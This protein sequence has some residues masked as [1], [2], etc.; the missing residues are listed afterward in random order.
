MLN[1]EPSYLRYVHDQLATGTLSPENAAAL[2]EGLIGLYEQEF[3]QNISVNKRQGLLNHLATWALFKGP[4]SAAMASKILN[5]SEGEV[6]DLIDRYSS[7]FNSPESGKYQ[8]YHE[9]LRVFIL[10]KL[11][12]NEIH[13][14]NEQIITY[15]E[16]AV[17]QADDSENE[18]YALQFLHN[19]LAL[20]SMLGVDYERL[21][22][23]VN[24]ESLW[25][26]Q[27]KV[28]KGY[29]WSQN[30][31][32]QGIKE[33]TRRKHEMNT[34]RSTVN[35]V[36]LMTQEQ[37]SAE[38]IIELLNEGDYHSALKR[39]ESWEGDRQFKLYLLFIHELTIGTSKEANFR[40]E[41]C[42]AVLEAIDQTPE[43]HSILDWT[44]FYPELAI[45][46]YYEQLLKMELD[47]MVIWK[48]GSFFLAP[49]IYQADIPLV[50]YLLP[51]WRSNSVK[52]NKRLRC[53]DELATLKLFVGKGY[54]DEAL[55]ILSTISIPL[56]KN[57]G[58]TFLFSTL[59]QSNGLDTIIFLLD[60]VQDD[61]ILSKLYAALVE[62]YYWANEDDKVITFLNLFLNVR[63][64]LTDYYER[65]VVAFKICRLFLTSDERI[66]VESL[67]N[68]VLI[69]SEFIEY[70]KGKFEV[71]FEVLELILVKRLV[72]SVKGNVERCFKV[73]S[74]ISSDLDRAS[75]YLKL[76]RL[77]FENDL[78][79]YSSLSLFR[80]LDSAS[81][82]MT[83]LEKKVCLFIEVFKEQLH[84]NRFEAA[85][86]TL[87]SIQILISEMSNVPY[88]SKNEKARVN[89]LLMEVLV[90]NEFHTEAEL[91]QKALVPLNT[92]SEFYEYQLRNNQLVLFR[93]NMLASLGYDSL[94]RFNESKDELYSSVSLQLAISAEISRAQKMIL[95]LSLTEARVDAYVNI[96]PI[97]IEGKMLSEFSYFYQMS[98]VAISDLKYSNVKC[99][100][101]IRVIDICFQI[102]DNQELN[103]ILYKCV[104]CSRDIYSNI[105]RLEIYL[106]I[107]EF[108]R[109]LNEEEISKSI[110]GEILLQLNE[111]A[112]GWIR[113]KGYSRLFKI[114]TQ[115]GSELK[116]NE[117]FIESLRIAKSLDTIRDKSRSFE[118]LVKV[119]PDDNNNDEVFNYALDSAENLSSRWRISS[120]LNLYNQ[121]KR[122][123][124]EIWAE[125]TLN[126][127]IKAAKGCPESQKEKAFFEIIETLID[128]NDNLLAMRL[129]EYISSNSLKLRIY[130]RL[131]HC[132]EYT[133]VLNVLE[134][135]NKSFDVRNLLNSYSRLISS[136]LDKAIDIRPFL[137]NHADFTKG[138][139]DILFYQAKIACF[140]EEDRNEEKLDI[141][142]EVLDIE[143]WRRIS[144]SFSNN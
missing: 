94:L 109:R 97:L 85:K 3:S 117:F 9:R 53:E 72:S 52:Q 130:S 26:R 69:E 20:E 91:V 119:L 49:I 7:W 92:V 56:Y 90:N 40:K 137:Q 142:S 88:I 8:L 27:I 50:L 23:Y 93:T 77:L 83:L 65:S 95:E 131:I 112:L 138:L 43:D 132:N 58:I 36:K 139:K 60:D 89:L 84:Q 10:Q 28:S 80:A 54:H 107:Y 22:N 134:S 64:S 87:K 105:N 136:S 13:A 63:S 42:K 122:R 135:V 116:A 81:K 35:S 44:K 124:A 143:D 1:L 144:A 57:K 121:C 30:A 51:L 61:F 14:L 120:L 129:I 32:Q 37:N 118:Y 62:Y 128:W 73:A 98:L 126:S 74:A 123:R 31:V 76:S 66:D 41:A 47:G 2:P 133:S 12:D 4:V 21:H 108:S 18:K 79:H 17:N 110:I 33:G 106:E 114:E 82:E 104:D 103:R 25:E 75:S 24:Q 115:H 29:E 46:K 127:A 45:Y 16:S 102:I 5:V 38:A 39:A 140:F 78:R 70:T 111:K 101:F 68:E 48:R 113:S 59:K 34:I 6:K 96:L 71:M 125:R 19:H 100:W 11:N 86:I 141:L 67:F 55:N 99:E 15:L